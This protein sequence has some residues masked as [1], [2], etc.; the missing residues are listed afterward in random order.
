MIATIESR[1][2]EILINSGSGRNGLRA[3]FLSD[4]VYDKEEK[5]VT[6][7][8]LESLKDVRYALPDLA[9]LAVEKICSLSN[10]DFNLVTSIYPTNHDYSGAI[11]GGLDLPYFTYIVKTGELVSI[12]GDDVP[13]RPRALI[14]DDVIFRSPGLF[15]AQEDLGTS[16]I[17]AARLFGLVD[18][19][20]PANHR[21]LAEHGIRVSS[22]TTIDDIHN[23]PAFSARFDPE[24]VSQ[25]KYWYSRLL[26]INS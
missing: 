7:F 12:S 24:E 13:N 5:T 6:K 16:G 8:H 20:L 18:Y 14:L 10:V 9:E 21:R 4:E 3:I 11:A 25:T 1:A 2:A 17:V 22:L 26:E 19:E 15:R 23:H